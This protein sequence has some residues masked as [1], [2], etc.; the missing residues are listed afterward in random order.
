[1]RQAVLLRNERQSRTRLEA[2]GNVRLANVAEVAAVGVD[3]IAV[4]AITHSAP[5]LDFSM[6]VEVVDGQ[7]VTKLS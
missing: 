6:L 1:M 7:P 2:S 3:A 5:A 4:D